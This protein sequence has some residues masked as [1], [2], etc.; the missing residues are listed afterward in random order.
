M[1]NSLNQD[2]IWEAYQNDAQFN[3]IGCPG[4]CR[5][6]FIAASIPKGV[7]VLN[8]GVG[9]G[10]L[11]RILAD[12]KVD[13]SCLDP[14]K[15]SIEKLRSELNLGEK[16]KV[17][18]AQDI[19]FGDERFDFV[20]MTEVLEHLSDGDL[21]STLREVVR[22]LRPGGYFVG[23]VPADESLGAGRIVCPYCGEQFHRWGHQQSFSR[24]RLVNELEKHFSKVSVKRVYFSD[25]KKLNWKGKL[26]TIARK[27]QVVLDLRGSNQSFYFKA[28]Y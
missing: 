6:E 23:S 26:S 5:I 22:V 13:L 25:F 19:P 24:Q 18:Y 27:I 9:V 2:K 15:T 8:I 12:K 3:D 16:A 21:F 17:G 11:E 20:V 14:S 28:E 1:N 7:T 10:D 4:G